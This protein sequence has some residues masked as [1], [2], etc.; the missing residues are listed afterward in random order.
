M[1]IVVYKPCS[2]D[3]FVHRFITVAI[4]YVPFNFRELKVQLEQLARM[5]FLVLMVSLVPLVIRARPP[6]EEMLA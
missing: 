4:V 3:A 6:H 5:E 1:N 2:F